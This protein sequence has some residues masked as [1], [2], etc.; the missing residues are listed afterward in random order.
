MEHKVNTKNNKYEGKKIM[1]YKQ[2]K[3]PQ[4]GI[5]RFR[6]SASVADGT[7]LEDYPALLTEGRTGVLI[8]VLPSQ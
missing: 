1:E 4:R 5:Y 7:T 2:L 3:F 6:C 8:M